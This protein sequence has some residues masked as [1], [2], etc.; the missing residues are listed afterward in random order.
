MKVLSDIL[1]Y[2]IGDDIKTC[3]DYVKNGVVCFND[4][5][6]IFQPGAVVVSAHNGPLSAFE[7]VE[8]EYMQNNC[9]KFLQVRCDCV[10][11]GGKEFGRYQEGI[12]IPQFIGTKKITGMK[13]YPLHFHEDKEALVTKLAKRGATFEKLAGH[14]YKQYSGKAITW[15][16]EGNE[17]EC[18]ITGR[19]IVDIDSFNRFSPWRVRYLND[20]NAKDLDNFTEHKE[21]LGLTDEK[22]VLPPNYQMLARSRTRGYS[23][24]FKKWLD[25]FVEQI[26]EVVW[27]STAFDKL[28]LPPDQKELILSFSESQIAGSSFDDIIQGKGKGIICL[29]SGPPGVGKTLT[30]EAVAENLK[31][32]LHMLSSGDLGS[33]PWEVER[34][35]NSILELVSRWNAILLLDECD[36]FL[37]ARST[38]ELERNKIVSIFLRTLEYYEGIMFMTTNRVEDIDAAFQSRIHVSIEYPDLTAASRRTIWANFLKGSTIKSSLTDNDIAELAELKL[39]GRQIKNVLKTAQLLASRKKSDTLDRKYIETILIIEKKRPGAPQTMM[40]YL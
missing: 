9:G 1:I 5:W 25:F 3:Q 18:Q 14:H 20:W 4:L 36:V 34:E 28:V 26:D 16:R 12:N 35:L 31:V 10:D 13:V 8:T 24:K 15:D 17:V 29:L 7:M 22:F 11:Y 6:M 30:A 39:N 23:L 21:K 2:E 37:E 27:N 40:H 32:P 38:H 19:I 33:D